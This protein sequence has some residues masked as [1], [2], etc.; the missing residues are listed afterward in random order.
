MGI[1]SLEFDVFIL[2]RP[3]LRGRHTRPRQNLDR[4]RD[5]RGPPRDTTAATYTYD[6]FGRLTARAETDFTASRACDAPG[7]GRTPV[8]TTTC[9]GGPPSCAGHP[10][11][12]S[13][14][15]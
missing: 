14:L 5:R 8:V 6:A 10:S 11:D 7:A 9:R 12:T 1:V 13:S 4:R 15:N 3:R 2:I